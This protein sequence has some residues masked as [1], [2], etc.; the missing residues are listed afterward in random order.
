MPFDV[1]GDDAFVVFAFA[2]ADG[3]AAGGVVLFVGGFVG[4]VDCFGAAG[5]VAVAGSA[6]CFGDVD[7]GLLV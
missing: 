4:A 6:V 2:A 1:V 3:V 7:L 5:D